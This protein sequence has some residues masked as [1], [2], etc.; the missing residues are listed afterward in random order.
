MSAIS[1]RPCSLH[2]EEYVAYP[3]FPD[4]SLMFPVSYD[5]EYPAECDDEFWEHPDPSRC[6]DQPE[7]KVSYMAYYTCFLRL[8][9][10][11]AKVMRYVVSL[12]SS[13]YS[14]G[15]SI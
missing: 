10:I 6:F 2:E 14:T 4:V 3:C 5:Q 12:P 7:N 15:V 8:V 9:K 13:T 1:G 11:L